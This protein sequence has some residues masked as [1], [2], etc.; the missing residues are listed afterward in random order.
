MTVGG[1][2]GMGF[3]W[4]LLLK[5]RPG[6]GERLKGPWTSQ[7]MEV[8]GRGREGGVGG[9][10]TLDLLI[11]PP[12]PQLALEALRGPGQPPSFGALPPV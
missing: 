5:A 11:L 12:Y 8:V 9:R 10:T 3:C 6:W 7:G 1:R 4:I 2:E